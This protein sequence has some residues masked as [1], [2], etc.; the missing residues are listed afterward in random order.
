MLRK[1]TEHISQVRLQWFVSYEPQITILQSVKM[2]FFTN[3]FF[4]NAVNFCGLCSMVYA[5]YIKR[6]GL[7]AAS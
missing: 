5:V 7:R 4:L 3:L 2:L 6:L 1:V